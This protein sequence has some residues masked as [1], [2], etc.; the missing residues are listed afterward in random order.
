MRILKRDRS[1]ELAAVSR[2]VSRSPVS[3]W[4][5][6]SPCLNGNR[7]LIRYRPRTGNYSVAV[8]PSPLDSPNHT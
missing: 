6:L 4:Q 8:Q 7:K 5:N 3:G 2:K 1:N